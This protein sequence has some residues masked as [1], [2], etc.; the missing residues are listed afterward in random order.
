MA[1]ISLSEE[2]AELGGAVTWGGFLESRGKRGRSYI[3]ALDLSNTPVQDEHLVKIGSL[4]EL[5]HLR[6]NDT[7][8]TD[9]GVSHLTSLKR[10]RQIELAGTEVSDEA[11]SFLS[12]LQTLEVLILSRTSISNA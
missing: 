5:T 3:G 6:L 12:Q 10:I 9:S 8:I 2:I 1:E 11:V 7:K 4:T